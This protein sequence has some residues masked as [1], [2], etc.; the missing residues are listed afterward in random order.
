MSFTSNG[1]N[2][3]YKSKFDGEIKV[4]LLGGYNEMVDDSCSSSNVSN[5]RRLEMKL[6]SIVVDDC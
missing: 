1:T 2:M 5:R 4:Y 6:T 3:I